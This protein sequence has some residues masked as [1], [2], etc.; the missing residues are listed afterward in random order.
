MNEELGRRI[1]EMIWLRKQYE[2]ELEVG[3]ELGL[4]SSEKTS[5]LRERK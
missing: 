1:I 5:V 4:R 3:E 2:W